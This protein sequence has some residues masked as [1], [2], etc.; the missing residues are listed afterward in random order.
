MWGTDVR[1]WTAVVPSAEQ[2]FFESFLKPYEPWVQLSVVR[3]GGNDDG[4]G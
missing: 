2:E 1:P 3:G 4:N